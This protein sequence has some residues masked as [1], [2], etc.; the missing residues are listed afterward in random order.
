[1]SSEKDHQK[2][3]SGLLCDPLHW[4]GWKLWAQKKSI[5]SELPNVSFDRRGEASLMM[6][7]GDAERLW[8]GASPLP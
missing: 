3:V 6:E 5:I 1:M 4:T 8:W 7:S 2:Q